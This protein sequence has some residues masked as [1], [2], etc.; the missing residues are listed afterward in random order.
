M[1]LESES[2]NKKQK[3]AVFA[4]GWSVE[5]LSMIIEGLRKEALKDCAD[6]F[7]Y[8]TFVLPVESEVT[9]ENQLKIYDIPDINNFDGAIILANTFTTQTELDKVCKLVKDF[10]IPTVTSEVKIP[11]LPMVGSDNYN[12]IYELT[13]HLIE[14]HGV[15]KI[16]YVRGVDGNVECAE[17]KRAL[18]DALEEHGLDLVDTIRGDFGF[19]VAS[20]VVDEWIKSGKP[21][22]DAFVCANDLMAL[23]V[24]SR[25]QSYGKRVPE[26]VLVT[27]FDHVHES[28]TSYPL[29][30]TVSRQWEHMGEYLYA[31]LKNQMECRDENIVKVYPS[32]FIPSESCGCKPDEEAYNVRLERVRN[33]YRN[34]T[35][36]DMIDFFFQRIHIEMAGVESKA[37]F[38][39]QAKW[40][41][42]NEEFFGRDYCIMIEPTFFDTEDEEYLEKVKD[43]SEKQD[44]IYERKAGKS[45]PL[46]ELYIKDIYPGYT[47]EMDKSNVFV[48]SALANLEH[49]IGLVA[50]KNS[51]EI[52]Y[53][54]QFK[55][56]LS[57]LDTLLLNIRNNIF[58][59]RINEQ[60][61]QIYMTDF[62]TD[63]Y[64]R[65]GCDNVLY[66]FIEE[67]RKAGRRSI[68]LFY[69]INC[70]KL[71]NDK[72]GHLN[73]DLAIKATANAIR[74]SLPKEYLCGRYGG[75]EFIA[76]GHL[77]D[78]AELFKYREAF[79]T[80]LKNIMDGLKVTFKLSASVGFCIIDPSDEGPIN[81]FIRK[82]DES[83]YEEKQRAHREM[84]VI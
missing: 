52:L 32:K 77:D 26:D 8:T 67:E 2:K 58:I 16:V 74:N 18:E 78:E 6:I 1:G 71:I 37:D 15:K 51:P 73:G 22:P 84:G 48:F 62:L 40:Q 45:C 75:D 68:L 66:S 3:I 35:E 9:R 14:K 44:I 33:I 69:D 23:G 82:A 47:E 39:E 50:V 10:K 57:N 79:G 19:Y 5:Y 20:Q 46:S 21:I 63:M 80:A 30:A 60:L 59:K 12:G 7:V 24:I 55:R 83:M 56:W 36:T 27:G 13:N 31:E 38:N 53:T 65:T 41:W 81:D 61:R 29:V 70:M 34:S 25:L 64:N 11:G 17:R 54:L 43:F 28:Q 42:G 4:N 76:V 72:Y 49:L